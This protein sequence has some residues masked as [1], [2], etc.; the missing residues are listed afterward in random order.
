MKSKTALIMAGGTGGHIFPGLALA[1]KL[2]QHGWN[3][4]WM[5]TAD[6]LEA[7]LVPK[8]NIPIHFIEIK[9]LRGNGLLRKLGFPF[10][11]LKAFLQAKKII[12]NM[13]PDVVIGF[14]GYASGPGGL[15]VKALNIPLIV[16]EQNAVLGMTNKWL[17]KF[18][19]HTCLAFELSGG[20]KLP[21]AEVIGNPVRHEIVELGKLPKRTLTPES[22]FRILVIGGSL[23]AKVFNEELPAL[24]GKFAQAHSVEIRHQCGKDNKT[25]VLA[26]YTQL[27]MD[28]GQLLVEVDEFIHDM[29]SAL[30]WCDLVVCRAGALTVSELAASGNAGIFVPLPHAVDDHQTANAMWLVEQSAGLLVPQANLGKLTSVLTELALNPN[31]INEMQSRANKVARNDATQ[32]LY[33]LCQKL[34]ISN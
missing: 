21:N 15:A 32:E 29:T 3:V 1:E 11:I 34:E 8:H 25:A 22:H 31:K 30:S 23:G 6:R 18:S 9:G 28:D 5:G 33:S 19:A 10:S 7:D 2:I 4:E 20:T 12:S 13:K 16:H 27:A 26:G 24:F 17:S 14:G